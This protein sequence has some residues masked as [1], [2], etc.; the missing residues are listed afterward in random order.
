MPA[1]T[2]TMRPPR[3]SWLKP[4]LHR[5][6][7]C[8]STR[9]R[10]A[11][12]RRRCGRAPTAGTPRARTGGAPRRHRGRGRAAGGSRPARSTVTG[13]D[14]LGDQRGDG[15]RA[16]RPGPEHHD[17]V[18][19]DD[20][21]PG[22][23]VQRHR[24]RLGQRRGAGREAV[25][26]RQQRAGVDQRRSRRT[27]RPGP[28]PRSSTVPGS[29]TATACPRGSAG[30][31]RTAATGRRPRHRRPPSHRPPSPTAATCRST[32]GPR[33]RRA[34]PSPRGSCGCPTRRSRSGRPR[35]APGPARR[36]HGPLLDRDLAPPGVHRARHGGW[37]VARRHL[38]LPG[39]RLGLVGWP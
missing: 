9:A 8:P 2:I 21:A 15:Q 22:D 7:S 31:G 28:G 16:D 38:M 24:Q 17:R 36:G 13:P 39:R 1:P 20:L 33:P 30:T 14:A 29:R 3:R 27:R 12:R 19:L 18:A 10:R 4:G 32:R 11:R 23:A 34:C 5:R 35:R 26:Q 37:Q 25:G 6:P